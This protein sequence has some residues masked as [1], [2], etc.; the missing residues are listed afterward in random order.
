MMQQQ[1]EQVRMQMAQACQRAGR[2]IEQVKLIAVTKAASQ[3]QIRQAA[4][5]GLCDLGENRVQQLAR[6]AQELHHDCPDL[7]WHMIGHLQRNKGKELLT[8]VSM[9]QSVDSERL[10]REINQAAEAMGRKMPVLL[11]VNAGEEEQKYGARPAEAMTLA[12]QMQAMANLQLCGVMSM[13]PLSDDLTLVRGAFARAREIFQ[14]IAAR[15][16]G[17]QYF[18]QLSMGMSHDFAI[19]IE[20]GSTMVR[21]GSLLFAPTGG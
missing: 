7:R 5:L 11:E 1:Y 16:I 6:R 17:E 14:Q 15:G 2:N 21:I 9:I 13:A 20:E 8:F 4:S 19:A 18:T 3:E 12:K 10:A